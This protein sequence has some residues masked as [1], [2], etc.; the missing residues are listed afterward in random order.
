MYKSGICSTKPAISLKRSNLEPNL[1]Q[2]VCRNSCTAC[3][4]WGPGNWQVFPEFCELWLGGLAHSCDTMR[5][6]ASVLDC[7]TWS[8][9]IFLTFVTVCQISPHSSRYKSIIIINNNNKPICNV[10]DA[11]VTDPEAH[12]YQKLC[13]HCR[14][15]DQA[16]DDICLSIAWST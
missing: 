15:C 6:C 8:S 3:W 1:L 13:I 4:Y 9:V 7:C 11:S 14:R 16:A 12:K 5:W 10:P 2:S